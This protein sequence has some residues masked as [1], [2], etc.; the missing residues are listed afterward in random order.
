MK[1]SFSFLYVWNNSFF[2]SLPSHIHHCSLHPFNCSSSR[3]MFELIPLFVF[4]LLYFAFSFVNSIIVLLEIWQHF[5][6]LVVRTSP[7]WS[8]I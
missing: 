1:F 7:S 3:T 8:T 2:W 4:L 6:L 5:M